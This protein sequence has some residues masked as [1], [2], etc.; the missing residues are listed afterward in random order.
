MNR[1][2]RLSACAA[3]LGLGLLACRP[4][5]PPEQPPVNPMPPGPVANPPT[6]TTSPANPFP[7]EAHVRR[8][9]EG[10]V[11]SPQAT[12]PAPQATLTSG[13]EAGHQKR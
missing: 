5:T 11:A 10:P 12:A 6:A 7:D 4:G 9:P 8:L 1:N 3:L 2:T 13:G